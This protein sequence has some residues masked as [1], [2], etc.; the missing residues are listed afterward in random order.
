MTT[1]LRRGGKEGRRGGEGE[2]GRRGEGGGRRE[3]RRN[4]SGKSNSQGPG[5]NP[6]LSPHFFP[7]FFRDF[8]TLSE[9]LSSRKVF[10]VYLC[11]PTPPPGKCSGSPSHDKEDETAVI[12]NEPDYSRTDQFRQ[13]SEGIPTPKDITLEQAKLLGCGKASTNLWKA[14]P[15][16]CVPSWRRG[17]LPGS[18]G[19]GSLARSDPVAGRGPRSSPRLPPGP[20]PEPTAPKSAAGWPPHSWRPDSDS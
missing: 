11:T 7:V 13:V 17:G 5:F 1:R 6:Q 9:S 18:R 16:A 4:L 20:P 19:R 15:R 8:F 3:E 12:C 14:Y 2:G 10:N